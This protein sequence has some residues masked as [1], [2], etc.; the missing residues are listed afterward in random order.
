MCRSH[1]GSSFRSRTLLPLAQILAGFVAFSGL[2]RAMVW[3]PTSAPKADTRS[4]NKPKFKKPWA[5]SCGHDKNRHYWTYCSGCGLEWWKESF[6]DDSPDTWARSASYSREQD[7]PARKSQKSTPT[8]TPIVPIPKDKGA[9]EEGRT[10]KD[11]DEILDLPEVK[12]RVEA[13]QNSLAGIKGIP[14]M[15]ELREHF[16]HM[17]LKHTNNL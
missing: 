9:E 15:G 8:P 12:L 5:C 17:I 14:D 1:F 13:L 6:E 11:G 4:N 7:P 3:Q 10:V 2:G 16:N